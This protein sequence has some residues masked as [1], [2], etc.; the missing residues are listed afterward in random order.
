MEI[1]D[2]QYLLGHVTGMYE[3]ENKIALP[4]GHFE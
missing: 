3:I 1:L 4:I 2:L